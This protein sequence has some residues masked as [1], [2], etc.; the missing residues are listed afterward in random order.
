MQMKPVKRVTPKK[1]DSLEAK[2]RYSPTKSAARTSA[3]C[4]EWVKQ[5]RLCLQIK[6]SPPV[7]QGPPRSSERENGGPDVTLCDAQ[8]VG[9]AR[10][11]QAHALRPF[12][13]FFKSVE[14]NFQEFFF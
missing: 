13:L 3:A 9:E 8:R 14:I 7:E 11:R 1:S 10:C 6:A 5:T 4:G 12:F 2:G